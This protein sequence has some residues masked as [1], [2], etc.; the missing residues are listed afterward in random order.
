MICVD[1]LLVVQSS[2]MNRASTLAL[3]MAPQGLRPRAWF[4]YWRFS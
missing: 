2:A 4:Y 3:S 1:H